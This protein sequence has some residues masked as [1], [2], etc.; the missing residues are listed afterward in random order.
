VVEKVVLECTCCVN[1]VYTDKAKTVI[2]WQ[3]CSVPGSLFVQRRPAV[4]ADVLLAVIFNLFSL[5]VHY[6][7]FTV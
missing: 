4:V 2:I 6:T 3:S 1:T 5:P 7:F